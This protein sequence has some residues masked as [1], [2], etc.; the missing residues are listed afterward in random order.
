[1]Q[2]TSTPVLQIRIEQMRRHA[3]G[4][5]LMTDTALATHLGMSPTT[6][7]RML[8]GKVRP[9]ERIIAVTL[10]AF[11]GLKFED[12]FEV[13]EATAARKAA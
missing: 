11:P 7:W 1:M 10:A 3:R 13:T 6:V 4:Q 12:F 5:G 8:N 2:Q 9:G